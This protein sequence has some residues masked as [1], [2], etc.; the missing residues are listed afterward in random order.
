SMNVRRLGVVMAILVGAGQARAE[1][2][3]VAAAKTALEAWNKAVSAKT[4][5]ATD[6]MG[7][8][9][10]IAAYKDANEL[11]C[12]LTITERASL[13]KART[14]IDDANVYLGELKPYTKKL[15]EHLGQL[16]NYKAEVEKL[17]RTTV[18]FGKYERGEG[19]SVFTLVA[20]ATDPS[21]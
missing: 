1:K 13:G 16:S 7:M 12:D 19:M 20:L 21:D 9:F 2:P 3:K 18:I 10:R 15:L 14:C 17:E 11:A 8:P 4:A 5:D 6:G